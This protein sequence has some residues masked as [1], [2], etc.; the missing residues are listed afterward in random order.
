MVFVARLSASEARGRIRSADLI[1]C[2]S[3]V[4]ALVG[5]ACSL[6]PSSPFPFFLSFLWCC[7]RFAKLDLSL[8]I[9]GV[10]SGGMFMLLLFF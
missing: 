6:L 10:L 7:F 9:P 5:V 8:V 2:P 4:S 1:S 3:P